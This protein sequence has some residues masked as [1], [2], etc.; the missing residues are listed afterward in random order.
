MSLTELDTPF[1]LPRMARTWTRL[2]EHLGCPPGPL[3]FDMV[4]QAAAD[5]LEETDDLD[6]KEMLPQPPRDGR[7]N[8]FAKDVAAMPIPVAG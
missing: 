8:E 2:H 6:W 5:N 7:W 4:R 3:T 1:T